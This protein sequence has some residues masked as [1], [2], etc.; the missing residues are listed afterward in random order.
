MQRR[1]FLKATVG[2]LAAALIPTKGDAKTQGPVV[3][4]DPIPLED[5]VEGLK[6]LRDRS[7]SFPTEMLDRPEN[8][9][10]D[11]KFRIPYKDD[12]FRQEWDCAWAA[13]DENAFFSADE[14]RGMRANYCVANEH[15]ELPEN[16]A[17]IIKK[18]MEEWN[19]KIVEDLAFP[20]VEF[21]ASEI[22]ERHA[23]FYGW[24]RYGEPV[25]DTRRVLLT[26][27]AD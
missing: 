14:I 20:K 15:A 2:C 16:Y 4:D 6:P 12:T 9:W 27:T 5:L 8:P 13:P 3:S 17:E 21:K 11:E 26:H 22:S 10:Y 18:A 23:G 24:A 7:M 1:G 19:Q 25:L